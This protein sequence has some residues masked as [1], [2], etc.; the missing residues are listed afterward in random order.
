[1]THDESPFYD[2]FLIWTPRW[3]PAFEDRQVTGDRTFETLREALRLSPENVPLRRH[4]AE[5]LLASGRPE[6]AEAE[7]REALNLAPDDLK[8][9]VGLANAFVE[10]GKND[11]A[12]V[13]LES[14]VKRPSA[15]AGA[16]VLYAR[17]LSHAGE[18]EE[19]VRQYHRGVDAD[20]SVADREFAERLGIRS[21][22]DDAPAGFDED[23]REVVEGRVRSAWSD[24]AAGGSI[25]IDRPDLKFT[26]VGGVESLKEEIRIKIIHPLNHAELYRAYGKAIGGGILLYGPPGCGKTYLARATAGEIQAGFLAVGINDVLEMWLGNSERNLHALFEQARQNA[27]C[28]L[29][30]DEVDALAASRADLRAS[31]GR[32]VINQFLA[33]LDGIGA[34]ND[35]CSSWPRPTPRGIST[36]HSGVR[37]GSIA[38]CSSHPPTR[39][40]V[41]RSFGSCAAA[42][43]CSMSTT[44]TSP[45]RP[46]SSRAPT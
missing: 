38:S 40:R 18:I 35:G 17:L 33:E 11:L 34:R 12:L 46:T 8:L 32:Q 30:F 9:K 20:S 36:R 7:Y 45:K 37:A 22:G 19:A 29:F 2:E 16:F 27:P 4:L 39:P 1:L 15:P 10:Q 6:L 26:E 13:I 28:V 41:P 31:A 3:R 23:N 25:E 21:A 43:P 14:V 42:S 44:T 24:S 5:S